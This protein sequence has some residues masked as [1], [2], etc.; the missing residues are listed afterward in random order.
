LSEKDLNMKI[1]YHYDEIIRV[2]PIYYS[3]ETQF[4]GYDFIYDLFEVE[5]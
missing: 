5:W 3:K 2:P 4:V 1:T